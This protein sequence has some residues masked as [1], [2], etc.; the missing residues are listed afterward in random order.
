[1]NTLR[2]QLLIALTVVGMGSAA[3]VQAQ[4]A[5]PEGRYGHAAHQQ[6]RIEKWGEHAAK[7]EAKLHDALKLSAEQEPAWNAY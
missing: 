6:E 3:A 7:R 5:A 4:T 2:K 1:M